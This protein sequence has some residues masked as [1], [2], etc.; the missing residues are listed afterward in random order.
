MKIYHSVYSDLGSLESYLFS[1]RDTK[2]SDTLEH[3][4]QQGIT[5]LLIKNTVKEEVWKNFWLNTIALALKVNYRNPNWLKDI[6]E[7]WDKNRLKN[8]LIF[9]DFKDQ[10]SSPSSQESKLVALRVLFSQIF[11]EGNPICSDRMMV[12]MDIPE[13]DAREIFKKLDLSKV[14]NTPLSFRF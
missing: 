6:F 2:I 12:L 10:F 4:V 7:D 9:S 11:G 5:E 1:F 3:R 13:A 14:L 8:I